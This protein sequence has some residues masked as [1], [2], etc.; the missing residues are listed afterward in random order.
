MTRQ[1]ISGMALLPTPLTPAPRLA[2]A[3]GLTGP[4]WVKRDDLT[5]FAVA[6]N[7]ARQLELLVEDAR[8]RGADVLVT[9]G[10]LGSNFVQAA[11]A[12]AAWAGLGCVLVLAGPPVP[13]SAHPNLAAATAWGA[14]V[15]FTDDLDRTTVDAQLPVVAAELTAAGCRPYVVPRGGASPVGAEG[16]RLA[17][18]EVLAQLD[19]QAPVVV[20]AAGAGGTLAGLVAGNVA[21][22]R[23]LRIVG[24]SVSR[25]PAEV[26]A[27]VLELACQ[28]AD[29]R[30][31]PRPVES[32]VELVDARGPGH[33]VA[34]PAGDAAA[35]LAL[36]AAG[37]VLDPVY[38]AKA[39]AA[40]PA[41]AGGQPALF[42]HTGGLL[43][44]IAGLMGGDG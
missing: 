7:K 4:L 3:L 25:P 13:R 37:L 9:G 1:G 22:G 34:S 39:L 18:D 11:A 31:E 2:T 14:E 17:V 32:D 28:V 21:L 6:G 8:A 27:R 29:R 19:G 43:D 33:G 20:I 26:S 35:A 40:L 5:G 38:T 10:T 36:R 16:Y 15:R 12:A 23:P 44:A 30:G 41:A 42:W 24:A